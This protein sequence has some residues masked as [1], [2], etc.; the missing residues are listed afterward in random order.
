MKL[1]ILSRDGTINSADETFVQ[2]VQDWRPLPGALDAIARLNHA[3]WQVVVASNQPG[4]GRGL[5]ESTQLN[6]IH[7]KLHQEL[8][9]VGGRVDAIFYC[10][11]AE[12][13]NCECRKPRSGL[14]VQIGERYGVDLATVLVVGNCLSDLQAGAQ[15]GCKLHCVLAGDSECYRGQT[16]GTEFPEGTHMHTD[17]AAFADFVIGNSA[18]TPVFKADC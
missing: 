2:R 17:L 7:S 13:E 14:F 8:A 10:P 6:M 1:I 3:G 16:V 15:V 18:A 4:L 9:S 12:D 5:L 11:H